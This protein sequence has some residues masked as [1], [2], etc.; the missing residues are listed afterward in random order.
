MKKTERNRVLQLDEKVS[1]KLNN[2]I[3]KIS[4]PAKNAS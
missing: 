4:D 2:I 3:S 1:K